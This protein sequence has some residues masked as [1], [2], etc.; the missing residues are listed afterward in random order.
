[1]LKVLPCAK[2]NCMFYKKWSIKF[3]KPVVKE[4]KWWRPD[5]RPPQWALR[6]AESCICCEHFKGFDLYM[7]EER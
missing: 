4:K 5:N 7:E 6:G 3:W 2:K 1:M